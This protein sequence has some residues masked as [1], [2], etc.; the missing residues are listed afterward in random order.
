V[1]GVPTFRPPAV[2]P[3]VATLTANRPTQRGSEASGMPGQTTVGGDQEVLPLQR[4]PCAPWGREDRSEEL[5]GQSRGVRELF[6]RELRRE[7]FRELLRDLPDRLGGR[8]WRARSGS[9]R[10]LVACFRTDHAHKR[11]RRCYV[12]PL[13]SA[14]TAGG[15]AV[16]Q[17]TVG[18][19]G[20][21]RRAM[22][23]MACRSRRSP[24]GLRTR[25]GSCPRHFAPKP[26]SFL[27]NR[28]AS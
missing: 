23:M 13:P 15:Q 14:T 20:N 16:G 2:C 27:M 21:P 18:D 1:E 26:S 5:R 3:A 28:S 22:Q 19:S 8:R 25:A 11:G 12:C 7:L 10:R 24:S 4:L 6:R 17:A 9:A